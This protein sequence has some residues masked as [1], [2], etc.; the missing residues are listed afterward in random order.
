[1]TDTAADYLHAIIFGRHYHPCPSEFCKGA[2]RSCS[3][4]YDCQPGPKLCGTCAFME[5]EAHA[6]PEENG[7]DHDDIY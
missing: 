3:D 1:M 4:Q 2:Q 6:T 7:D 5:D